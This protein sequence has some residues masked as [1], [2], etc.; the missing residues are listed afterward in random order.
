[1]GIYDDMR[2]E[3]EAITTGISALAG[4]SLYSHVL[5]RTSSIEYNFLECTLA[6]NIYD[7][8][9]RFKIEEYGLYASYYV[10]NKKNFRL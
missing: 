5:W 1:M 4:A 6:Q 7:I 10:I 2:I 9:V 3:R 8:M